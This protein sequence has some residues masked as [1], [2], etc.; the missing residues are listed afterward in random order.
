M[1]R[2]T[3]LSAVSWLCAGIATLSLAGCSTE[4]ASSAAV[5]SAEV[6]SEAET[7][8]ESEISVESITYGVIQEWGAASVALS[9]YELDGQT[10]PVTDGAPDF[11][12]FDPD[13]MTATADSVTVTVA[14]SPSYRVLS[15]G[16][17]ATASASD[18]QTGDRVAVVDKSD[19]SQWWIRLQIGSRITAGIVS[20][21]ASDGTLTLTM[22][23]QAAD[24]EVSTTDWTQVDWSVFEETATAEYYSIPD[25]AAVQKLQSGAFSDCALDEIQAGDRMLI[26]EEAHDVWVGIYP[27][28]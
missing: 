5:S 10:V 13:G 2:Q 19:G 7:S 21:V 17:V 1:K 14:E 22:M 24:T 16:I 15:D 27:A 6:S 9:V 28:T 26:Y 12:A 4:A 20:A 23:T 8:G 18:F 3:I 25:Q 11:S